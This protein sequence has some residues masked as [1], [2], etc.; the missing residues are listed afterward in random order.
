MRVRPALEGRKRQRQQ[1]PNQLAADPNVNPERRLLH[2][3][4]ACLTQHIVKHND[5]GHANDEPL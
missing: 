4:A 5:Q 1:F 2:D 3:S